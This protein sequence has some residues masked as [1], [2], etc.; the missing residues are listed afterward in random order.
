MSEY[1]SMNEM[2]LQDSS[3]VPEPRK[4]TP[5]TPKSV[6]YTGSRVAAQFRLPQDLM[7]SLRLHAIKENKSLSEIAEACLSSEK[8]LGKA[9]VAI[10]DAA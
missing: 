5:R 6:K 10:R 3:P 2:G 7:Q 8:Y 9:H 4:E 1:R